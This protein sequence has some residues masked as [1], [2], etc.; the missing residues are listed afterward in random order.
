MAASTLM[1]NRIR[2]RRRELAMSQRALAQ[3]VG[4][5]PSYM[6]LIENDRRPVTAA[7]QVG[8]AR[9]L[10]VDVK[11]FA[12]DA[13]AIIAADLVEAFSDPLFEAEPAAEA[14]LRQ[15]ASRHPAVGGAMLALYR[16]YRDNRDELAAISERLSDDRYLDDA[17]FEF[18]SLLTTVRSSSEILRD[19]A[20]M[21]L[22]QRQQFV[23]VIL[24]D[25]ARLSSVIDRLLGRA[26]AGQYRNVG[27]A[28]SAADEVADAFQSWNNHL[29][30]LEE[31]AEAL[32]PKLGVPGPGRHAGL[33]AYLR[34]R[35]GVDVEIAGADALGGAVRCYAPAA[36]RLLLSDELGHGSRTFQLAVQVGLLEL[37][38]AFDDIVAGTTFSGD[39]SRVLCRIA[40]A[41]Y[42]AAALLMP[43]EPFLAAARALRYDIDRLRNRYGVSFEQACHRLT[44]LQRPGDS[45]V[46]FHLIRVDI[47]GNISLRFSASGMRIPRYGGACPRWNVHAAFL[48]PGEIVTQLAAMP[49]GR[50]FFTLART[51]SKG[52]AF[53]A[54]RSHLSIGLGCDADHADQLVYADGVDLRDRDR[55]VPVG[56]SCRICERLDCRQRA[57]TPISHRLALDVNLRGPSVHA[58]FPAPLDAD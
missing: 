30:V 4:I 22:A 43:Y 42:F 26:T 29:A 34:D 51:V 6:N 23:D 31:A 7:L 16:A 9:A 38:P 24:N 48:T 55:A 20:D 54:P 47:A 50:A 39:A 13:E 5:S 25:S 49:D 11:T 40:L 21:P 10:D 36:K 17:D 27:V 18:R 41:N 56:V 46:P 35:H 2:D 37:R 52:G 32:G 1:G 57:F 58:T 53:A 19:N 14:E 44:T 45:G 28:R 3:R 8:I 12:E 33:I 15:L